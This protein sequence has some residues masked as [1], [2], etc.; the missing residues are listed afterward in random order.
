MAITS[1]EGGVVVTGDD[2]G[3]LKLLAFRGRLQLEIKGIGFSKPTLRMYNDTYGTNFNRKAAALED[4][5]SRINVFK[6]SH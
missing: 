5:I 2:V 1:T 4:C 3:L 6:D